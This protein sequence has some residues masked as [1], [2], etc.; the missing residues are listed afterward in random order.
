MDQ[1]LYLRLAHL[2]YY[3]KSL[4]RWVNRQRS[5]FAKRK[6]KAE[7]VKKLNAIGLKWSVHERKNGIK[8][9]SD[10]PPMGGGCPPNPTNP[11]ETKKDGS[12]MGI[13]PQPAPVGNNAAP[14]SKNVNGLETSIS[15]DE[16]SPAKAS[17]ISYTG[18]TLIT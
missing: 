5:A 2:F 17:T 15:T 4:G 1:S 8:N 6:L 12:V 9:S 3:K 14:V 10:S 11:V 13:Q 7:W 16:I 18:T